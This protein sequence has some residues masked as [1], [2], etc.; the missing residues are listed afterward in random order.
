MDC[1]ENK[2]R[3]K[4]ACKMKARKKNPKQQKDLFKVLLVDLIDTKHA[5]AQLADGIDWETFDD[6]LIDEFPSPTGRP[7]LPTR[8]MVGL[9]YLKYTYNI[10]DEEVLAGWLENPYWQYFCGG[11]YF[12]HT[13]PVDPSSL[14]RW[15][16]YLKESGAENMLSELL[17]TGLR[18]KLIKES[19]FERVIV[20]TTV[21]EKNVRYPTD[22]RLYDRMRRTLVKAAQE[23]GIELR[24]TYS[25]K[26]PTALLKQSGYARA[27]QMKRAKRETR[28]LW[29][30]LGRVTRDI[31][32]KA[33]KQDRELLAR[34]NQLLRQQRE[35]KNKM[36]SVHAPEVECISKG[37]ANKR[38]E[39]GC[40]VGL[41]TTAKTNWIVGAKAFHNNPYDG[42][43]LKESL[44][45]VRFMVGDEP[46]HIYAD[47]G[48]R[49]HNY[50]GEGEVHI[51]YR[52]KRT[53]PESLRK[54]LRRRNAIEP[55]IGHA[56][57]EHG[58]GRN[59]L[60]GKIGDKLNV[61][62]AACGFNMRKLMAAIAAALFAYIFKLLF[63]PKSLLQLPEH[64]NASL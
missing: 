62:L 60:K 28:R 16:S 38:W 8:M 46:A 14:T 13:L 4:K 24:Q 20:D 45:Q 39:F 5:L 53:I 29:T 9:M 50:K 36:Y 34:S 1:K 44:K 30:Y 43:T 59:R 22:A 10:S 33:P 2:E 32:R 40:K 17:M 54:W 18:T 7:A 57:S 15:R 56:K 3:P 31:E 61:V 27:Q 37:K 49:G 63:L 52:H 19:E 51:A 41:A 6:M 11:V 25:R 12:E 47:M 64:Q 55:V 48:Y 42:H 58:L 21:Q 26:G 23:R 35:N